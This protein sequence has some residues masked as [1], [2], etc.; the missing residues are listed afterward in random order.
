MISVVVPCG[1]TTLSVLLHT[2]W[3]N[4]AVEFAMRHSNQVCPGCGGYTN[5]LVSGSLRLRD[6]CPPVLI[7][8]ETQIISIDWFI[9]YWYKYRLPSEFHVL[10]WRSHYMNHLVINHHFHAIF[11]YAVIPI[12]RLYQVCRD[13][14]RLPQT[15][16]AGWLVRACSDGEYSGKQ[17]RPTV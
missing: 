13:T 3:V 2:L 15:E 9:G 6:R 4:R 8:T 12:I 16:W 10:R 5:W 7:S 14:R 17:L 1:I 11:R